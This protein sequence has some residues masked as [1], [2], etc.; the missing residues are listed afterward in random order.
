[1]KIRADIAGSNKIVKV[2]FKINGSVK[3]TL[4][5]A[6]PWEKIIYVPDGIPK[7]KCGQ[8]MK[9]QFRI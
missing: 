5:F 8:K 6:S 1:M 3:E 7:V 2:E 9:R 4:R